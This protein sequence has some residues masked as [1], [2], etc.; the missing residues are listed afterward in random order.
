V[1]LDGESWSIA[2]GA[3]LSGAALRPLTLRSALYATQ[4]SGRVAAISSNASAGIAMRIIKLLGGLLAQSR[5]LC[6]NQCKLFAQTSALCPTHRVREPSFVSRPTLHAAPE[7]WAAG[8]SAEPESEVRN[9]CSS[10]E[11]M[12]PQSISGSLSTEHMRSVDARRPKE[13]PRHQGRGQSSGFR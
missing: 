1:R 12:L 3:L 10:K 2:P 11:Q 6:L 4:P 8:I 5:R 9:R 7:M 13:K